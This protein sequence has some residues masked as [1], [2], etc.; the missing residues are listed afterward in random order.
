MAEA[1][2]AIVV[3]QIVGAV[4]VAE[5]DQ[6]H[7]PVRAVAS[8]NGRP[9]VSTSEVDGTWKGRGS[10]EPVKRVGRALRAAAQDEGHERERATGRP[11]QAGYAR[12]TPAARSSV[13]ARSAVSPSRPVV[14]VEQ[15]AHEGGA[16]DHRVGVRRHLGGL[17]AVADPEPDP[18]RQVGDP[19]GALDQRPGEVAGVARAPVTPITAVA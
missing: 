4:G 5:E 18:D 15:G 8:E 10:T 13:S 1:S 17:V 16:D 12:R 7:P 6:G 14:V 3:G 19:P 9:S 2:V 11:R